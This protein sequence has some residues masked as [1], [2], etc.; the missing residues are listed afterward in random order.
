MQVENVVNATIH[1]RLVLP[2]M[3]VRMAKQIIAGARETL[4][5]AEDMRV[6]VLLVHGGKDTLTSFKATLEFGRRLRSI[7]KTV[8]IYRGAFHEIHNDIDR[9]QLF[10]EVKDWIGKRC[11]VQPSLSCSSFNTPEPVQDV[12]GIL[13]RI[14]SLRR[15]LLLLLIFV[16]TLRHYR[17]R[18]LSA[19]LWPLH[20]LPR[21]FHT[22]IPL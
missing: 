2:F 18:P 15:L 14:C 10:T 8:R 9:E 22:F 16:L 17:R 13:R 4:K 3:T 6:P 20:Y 5:R 21:V 11:N 7:D 12:F 1:D 19:M